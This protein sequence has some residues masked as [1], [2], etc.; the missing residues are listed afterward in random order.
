LSSE[1]HPAEAGVSRTFLRRAGAWLA[2]VFAWSWGIAALVA[3]LR[4]PVDGY[5]SLLLAVPFLVGPLFASLLWKRFVVHEPAS[6]LDTSLRFGGVVVL[7]WLAPVL[8][9]WASAFVANAFGW[10][11]LDL[12]GGPIVERV[13]SLRGEEAA[14]QMRAGLDASSVPYPL[15]ASF[16]ALIVGLF[17]YA[18][19]AF[20]E[21]IG[22]RGV[23][24]RE[25]RPLGFWP[26]ALLIGL[27]WG[28]WHAP[29]VL[30]AGHFPDA[31]LQGTLVLIGVSIPLGALLAWV[32]EAS[33]TVWA[34]AVAHGVLNALMGFHELILHEGAP[35]V[36]GVMGV[37]GGIVLLL[38]AV[39]L[40]ARFPAGP[41]A[42]APV[43]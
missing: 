11:T 43:I 12:T 26:A 38:V 39:A 42:P 1:P 9:V 20:A 4:L 14:A 21:E 13:L 32:R 29:L 19:L 22:W 34:A 15:L 23:L 33:G 2:L 8:I 16:Q 37:A 7:S 40:F 30:L 28:I 5:W 35:Q 6:S 18:P 27:A 36:V 25:L 31:P 17:F 24:F 10:A 3:A 41:P